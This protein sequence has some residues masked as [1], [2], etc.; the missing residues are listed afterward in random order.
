MAGSFF[1]PVSGVYSGDKSRAKLT[2]I[3]SVQFKRLFIANSNPLAQ[4]KVMTQ[5]SLALKWME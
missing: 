5:D 1:S 2:L 3:I 4:P